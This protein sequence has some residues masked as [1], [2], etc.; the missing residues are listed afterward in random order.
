[1]K[2]IFFLLPLFLFA[3]V[4]PFNVQINQSS[5]N[6]LTP[7]EKA[8]LENK[9]NIKKLNKKTDKLSSQLQNITLKLVSYD[10]TMENI[11]QKTAAF[12]TI[13]SE[14]GN[15]KSQISTLKNDINNT[16]KNYKQVNEKVLSLEQNITKMQNEIDG[17]K[18]S[19][20][21]MADIQNQNFQYLKNS[22]NL[23]LKT[24]NKKQK[25]LNPR[26][27][28]IKAKDLFYK[29]KYIQARE[30]FLYT[31]SK[32]YLPATSSY[33]LGEIAFKDGNYKNALAYY[34]KSIELYPKKTSFT[35][36]LLYHTAI[37]FEKLGNK[38]AAKLTF[39]KLINDF[40]KSK[41]SELAKKKVVNLK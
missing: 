25:P 20:K 33:Y 36:R 35:D 5:Y 29:G 34:K 37:S 19:I 41:Y 30:L 40:P 7:Q 28:M 6:A 13:L 31:L 38:K 22:I 10:Q 3:D 2:K 1:M 26:N 27:A 15:I 24:I 21:A 32:K 18:A 11:Q 16:N 4:N 14:L 12:D 9:I 17:I 23:I 8:I 39:Q